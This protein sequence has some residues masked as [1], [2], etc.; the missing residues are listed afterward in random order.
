MEVAVAAESYVQPPQPFVDGLGER[1]V[2]TDARGERLDV[3]RLS[4]GL[5][6]TPSFESALRE[7]AS[8]IAGFRH[9]SFSHVRSIEVERPS[10]TLLVVSDHVRGARLST[11]LSAA[12][13]RSIPVDIA[14]A[15]CLI[16]QLVHAVAA[17]REQMP[18]V[19]H[20]A[21]GPD[22]IVI[23][24][25][26][27][28]VV[29]E[30]VLGSALEQLRYSRQQ[31]WEELGVPLPATFKFAINA[32]A[33]VLQVGAV[34]L[35]LLLGRRLTASDRIDEMQ[36]TLADRVMPPLRTWLLRALQ[37]EPV[38]SYTSVLDARAA[39]DTALGDADPA[40]EQDGLLLF[41]A[42]CLSLDVD[43]APS[44]ERTAA[45]DGAVPESD[46]L[47][48]VDLGIRIEA[49]RAFL[50]R[51]S[52]H[53]GTTGAEDPPLH[54][55]SAATSRSADVP[56][57][58]AGA[59]TD[60]TDDAPLHPTPTTHPERE[61]RRRSTASPLPVDWTRR[62]WIAAAATLVIGAALLLFVMGGVPWP[63]GGPSTGALSITT[64]PP[65][66]P[67]TIDGT[68]RGVTP[69]A[70]DLAA[71]DHL[72][73]L[74]TDAEHRKIPVTIRAGSESSQFLE[75]GGGAAATTTT[76]ELRVRTE[77]LGASVTVDGRYVGRSPVS[78]TDL[79]PGSHTVVLRHETESATEQVLIEPG[80]TAS[81]FVPLASRPN[82][83][84]AGWISV[85][86]APV[87][88]QLFESGRFLGSSR[89][90][91]I[92]LPAGRHDLDIINEA[93]GYQE[94]RTVRVDAGQT[95]VI[96]LKWPTGGLSLNAVPWAQAF[97]DGAPVGETPI[98][99]IQVPIGP[100]DILFRHPQL[101]ERRTSVTVT[102]RE[103]SRVGVDLRK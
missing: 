12:E 92:M 42:R 59:A 94:R 14:A 41:M 76:S 26:G 38:G 15:T 7:R 54:A 40:T 4:L 19:V 45:S 100:H 44:A 71:G 73:E 28:L 90:D 36:Q 103:T 97:V 88:V 27:R 9:E 25:D 46:D 13:K 18:D 91:R 57:S 82:T 35:A 48:D 43:T 68:P 61:P 16:R 34:A 63:T 30:H 24:P 60:R 69:L 102:T 77:P 47:P 50:A 1:R 95:A 70:I 3:L 22:R 65:G 10:G 53:T 67:V 5:S 64:Q 101:G 87:D 80:K 51:R 79:T 74:V 6:A 23:T 33:D 62:L 49:L 55:A 2:V 85:T 58:S 31:Y 52:P 96:S 17:W 98:A 84:A 8:R 99:N 37:L 81:L 78:V 39:L 11:L 21:I 56:L 75:M 66:I 89:I 93:L 32:R 29:V 86:S 20:G 72:V 83:T